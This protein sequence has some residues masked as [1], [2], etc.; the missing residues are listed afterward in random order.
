MDQT[1]H[2]GI[3]DHWRI[4]AL[5]AFRFLLTSLFFMGMFSIHASAQRPDDSAELLKTEADQAR[6]QGNVTQAIDLYTKAV[7]LDS[8]W[9]D[10]W[11]YL[12]SLQYAT[13][14]Y[15]PA[16]T[17]L[18]HYIDL[19]PKAGPAFALRGLCEFEQKQYPKSLQDLQQAIA[20]GAANQPKNAGILFYHEALLLTMFG[21]YEEALTTYGN[22][23]K[24]GMASDEI[25]DGIGLA[26]L[27]LPMLPYEVD[28][29]RSS[30]V[31]EA[32]KAAASILNDQIDA[33]GQEFEAFFREYPTLPNV[34][35]SF[36]YLLSVA[37]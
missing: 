15:G 14:A 31:F 10:G 1:K 34:H 3:L 27:R 18:T 37:E 19:V 7:Q 5:K 30:Q 26:V 17:A 13:N 16:V 25:I 4:D 29:K 21:R 35:Y 11:W 28:V 9:P 36:G 8:A 23:L 20:L 32:G 2:F 22:M 12:G 33:G 6:V 24:H